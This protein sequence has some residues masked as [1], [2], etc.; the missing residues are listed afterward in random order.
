MKLNDKIYTILK[1]CSCCLI[2][3]ATTLYCVLSKTWDWPY[4][5]QVA[6]TSAAVCTFMG[7][8][9][10]ISTAE[11]NRSG[12]MNDYTGIDYDED[13]Y[14]DDEEEGGEDGDK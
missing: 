11:Y 7:A 5:I 4:A 12:D 14:W 2:P 1:W 6:E 3:A 10:G 9:L 13:M 8:I